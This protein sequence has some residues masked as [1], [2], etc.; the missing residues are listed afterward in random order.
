MLF[1][2]VLKVNVAKE[3]PAIVA[4]ATPFIIGMPA[5]SFAITTAG[6]SLETF[7]FKTPSCKVCPQKEAKSKYFPC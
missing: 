5:E 1:R 2:S 7:T 4:K 3:T 6:V